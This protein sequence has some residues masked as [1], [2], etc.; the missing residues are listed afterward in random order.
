MNK[1]NLFK[2]AWT[3]AKEGAAKFGGSSREYFAEALKL[4]YKLQGG[5]E[6]TYTLEMAGGSRNHKSWVAKVTGKDAKWGFK[7][8]FIE[9]A[10]YGEWNLE[11]GVYN[12]KDASKNDQQFIVVKNGQMT[13][14]EKEEVLA[15]I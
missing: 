6:M 10:D 9:A 1:S 3:I 4:A 2:T 7:R 8:E 15:N 12:I 5:I 14:I 11:D 13:E